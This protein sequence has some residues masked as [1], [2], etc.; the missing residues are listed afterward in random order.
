MFKQLSV[1]RFIHFASQDLL[2][3]GDGKSRDFVA[4]SFT[5]TL[6]FLGSFSTGIFDDAVS[7]NLSLSLSFIDNTLSTLFTVGNNG[8]STRTS[9]GFNGLTLFRSDCKSLFALVGGSEAICNLLLPFF[10]RLDQRRP[11]VL[12]GDPSTKEEHNHLYKQR[13]INV[14]Y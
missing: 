6:H 3:T 4:Q 11:N 10:N 8:R 12:H 7:L 14:H 2:G 13:G 9:V 1:N 5:G